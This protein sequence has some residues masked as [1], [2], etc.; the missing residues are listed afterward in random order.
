[1]VTAIIN[2]YEA[3]THHWTRVGVQNAS[4]VVLT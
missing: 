3:S 1:M 4:E 2:D